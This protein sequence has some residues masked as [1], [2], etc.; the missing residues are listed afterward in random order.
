MNKWLKD[1]LV[2]IAIYLIEVAIDKFKDEHLITPLMTL[3]KKQEA[4]LKDAANLILYVN[5][6][7]G[8]SCTAGELW[9]TNEQ[10]AIYL[11]K[12]L[13]KT[14]YS[15]H[16]DRLAIDLNIFIDGK[17]RTDRAAFKPVAEYWKSLDPN[18]VSG[19]DWSWDYNHFER[20]P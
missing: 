15:R 2:K 20:K 13:T 6:L 19:Y 4:F 8:Y 11:A 5:T 17:Y 1:I 18:N 12:G 7:P 9:R 10:H 16:Q 3:R 14:K